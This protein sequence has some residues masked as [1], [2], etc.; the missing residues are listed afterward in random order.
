MI[1]QSF[2][3][4]RYLRI[5]LT[6]SV[7]WWDGFFEKQLATAVAKAMSGLG[8]TIE[9]I[10][11]PVICWYLSISADEASPSIRGTSIA[12]FFIGVLFGLA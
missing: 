8:S 9:N 2:D 6:A 3:P 10:K 11:D 12:A 7:C 4:L 1:P 5:D